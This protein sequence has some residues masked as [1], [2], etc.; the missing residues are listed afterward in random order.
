MIVSFKTMF[1]RNIKYEDLRPINICLLRLV[2][3]LVMRV[4]VAAAAYVDQWAGSSTKIID[5]GVA[6]V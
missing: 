5:W 6:I 1:Q 4:L 3:S 2:Y